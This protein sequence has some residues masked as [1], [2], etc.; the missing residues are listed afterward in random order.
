MPLLKMYLAT[1]VKSGFAI[2]LQ[3][4]GR[5]SILASQQ[6]E[7]CAAV[8]RRPLRLRS[9]LVSGGSKKLIEQSLGEQS[10]AV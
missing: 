6:R 1:V 8:A 4:T 3:T 10:S 7:S 5:Q 2:V 9:I